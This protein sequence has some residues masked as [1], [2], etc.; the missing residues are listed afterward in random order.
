LHTNYTLE[1]IISTLKNKRKMYLHYLSMKPTV[2]RINR[3]LNTIKKHFFNKN[4]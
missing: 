4:I 1:D 3:L 2:M